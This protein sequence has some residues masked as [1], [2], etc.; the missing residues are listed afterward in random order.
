MNKGRNMNT[1]LPPLKGP[2]RLIISWH[3]SK[4]GV[5]L[6]AGCIMSLSGAR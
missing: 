4:V 6:Y 5:L 1:Y 2:R 3:V